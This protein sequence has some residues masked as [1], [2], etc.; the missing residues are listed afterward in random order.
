MKSDIQK[1]IKKALAKKAVG[2]DAKEIVEEY[3]DDE[4]TLRLTKK[5]ITKKHIP[6]D[7]QAAKIVL[8][9]MDATPVNAMT[10]EQ[11]NAEKERIINLLKENEYDNKKP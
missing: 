7:T 8:E 2:Y 11:L 1:K 6:P 10:D 3:Q 4:G 5:K 9:S